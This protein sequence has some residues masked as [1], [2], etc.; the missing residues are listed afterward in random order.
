MP[1][2]EVD[3]F[4]NGASI[5]GCID[6]WIGLDWLSPGRVKYVTF[7][8]KKKLPSKVLEN[9][10]D[11]NQSH[12]H[13]NTLEDMLIALKED[14]KWDEMS[15]C[16]FVSLHDKKNSLNNIVFVLYMLNMVHAFE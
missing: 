9:L 1:K 14:L 13:Q 16:V 15:D 6:G 8:E 3:A 12:F 7:V 10:A 5:S 11:K 4:F 2:I